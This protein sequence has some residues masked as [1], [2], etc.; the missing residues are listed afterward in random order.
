MA[1][2]NDIGQKIN[3]NLFKTYLLNLKFINLI[4]LNNQ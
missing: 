4:L 2:L 1:Q 3:E